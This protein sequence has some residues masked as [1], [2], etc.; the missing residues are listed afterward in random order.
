MK[1]VKLEFY[2][3]SIGDVISIGLAAEK[4]TDIQT[5]KEMKLKGHNFAAECECSGRRQ[6]HASMWTFNVTP[7]WGPE[8]RNGNG[9]LVIECPHCGF[10]ALEGHWSDVEVKP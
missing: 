10:C 1:K 7:G 6:S 8:P 4:W 2:D 5:G 9:R 3:D